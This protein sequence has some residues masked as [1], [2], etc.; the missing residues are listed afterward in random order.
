MAI[1]YCIRKLNTGNAKY[2]REALEL[3]RLS[4]SAGLLVK[5]GFLPAPTYN[6]IVT[7]S[8]KENESN[9]AEN[10]IEEY[11]DNLKST[12]RNS[13]YQFCLAK[14]LFAQNKYDDCL[15]I[16]AKIANNLP[17]IYLG[18]KTMQIKIF[19]ENKEIEALESL[20]ESLRVYLQR[21]KDLGYRKQNYVN[22]I[23]FS[24][25][26]LQLPAMSKKEKNIFREDIEAAEIFTEK[27][28]F[29][30]RIK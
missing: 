22:L 24:K 12:T 19:I 1:N 8:I 23:K 3:Y 11:K 7:L 18:A 4:L 27:K 25:K 26:L 15:I 14:I 5:D 2:N 20:L 10:F 9:W 6:N 29:V 28:W 13:M 16:L 21:R 30:A 17:F